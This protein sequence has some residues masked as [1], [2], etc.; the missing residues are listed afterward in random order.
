MKVCKF[1][2]RAENVSPEKKV[3]VTWEGV[4]HIKISIPSLEMKE[5]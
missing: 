2:N 3:T 1:V 5:G 4:S